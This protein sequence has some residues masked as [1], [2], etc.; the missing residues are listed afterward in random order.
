MA[1]PV[2]TQ[3]QAGALTPARATS[4]SFDITEDVLTEPLFLLHRE[5]GQMQ[6]A[7]KTNVIKLKSGS[8][9]LKPINDID[10]S[11]E[12]SDVTPYILRLSQ[13]NAASVVAEIAQ[14]RSLTELT[15]VSPSGNVATTGDYYLI[16]RTA[17]GATWNNTLTGSTTPSVLGT[18]NYPLDRLITAP[19]TPGFFETDTGFLLRLHITGAGLSNPD[20]LCGFE[21]GGSLIG[22]AT[23]PHTGFGRFWLAL[24]GDGRAQLYEYID[25]AWTQVAAWRYMSPRDV[26]GQA[27]ILRILPTAPRHLEFT[28][29]THGDFAGP[30]ERLAEVTYQFI[31]ALQKDTYLQSTYLHTISNRGELAFLPNRPRAITGAG[32][33]GFDL[34]RDLRAKFQISRL[35]YPT[36]PAVGTILERNFTLAY[37]VA[38]AHVMRPTTI[39]YDYFSGDTQKTSH[40][41]ILQ[42]ADGSSLGTASE[43]Y[44]WR[45]T[46]YSVPG[47]VPAGSLNTLRA[48]ITLT[49]LE[50]AGASFHTPV[51]VGYEVQR[52][53]HIATHAPGVKSGGNLQ[54]V[55]LSGPGYEPDQE[56]ASLVI[57]DVENELSFLRARGLASVRV[58][59]TDPADPVN[60]KVIC[61]EGYTG[62]VNAVRRGKTGAVYPSAQ[63]RRLEI[64]C[65]GKW[66]RLADRFFYQR[67]YFN[68][69]LTSPTNP[70][71]DYQPWKVTDAIRAI[72]ASQGFG[73][74]QLDIF[75]DPIRIFISP[76]GDE[77]NF[78]VPPGASIPEF[79]QMLA[80]DYLN[81]YY[82]FDYAARPSGATT[83]GMWRLRRPP[84]GTETPLWN[85]TT[86]TVSGT[87]LAYRGAAYGANTSPILGDPFEFRSYI[88]PPEGNVLTVAGAEID[89]PGGGTGTVQRQLINPTSWN[90]PTHSTASSADI[91]YIGYIKPIEYV[92]PTIGG[93]PVQAQLAIDF[94]ARRIFN[95]ACRGRKWFEFVSE[96][97]FVTDTA[98]LADGGAAYS[99]PTYARRPLLP[100]DL[101]TIDGELCVMHSVNAIW[102]KD[103][104][105]WAHYEAELFRFQ[106]T[107]S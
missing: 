20:V 31:R 27:I 13:V 11:P 42:G 105:Q 37:G 95:L 4:V 65:V 44:T 78:S 6:P 84:T 87:K 97:C 55:S 103:V 99:N 39:G 74:T 3:I 58:E 59:T 86:A 75:D 51:V 81:A 53:G 32:P 19:T 98:T 107:F 40:G 60:K 23:A 88:I 46:A 26:P 61:F 72:L 83:Q 49:N 62:R 8:F 106:N 66:N 38:A 57:Q 30:M 7:T 25:A 28:F 96:Y 85:F 77:N 21:F 10:V 14:H 9:V 1:D 12:R 79:L 50:G 41:A 33:I 64:D 17:S 73:E 76:H 24:L 34:R 102:K 47:Y 18:T 90:S 101:V 36:S 22:D 80:I 52:F 94:L 89:L 29:M 71:G 104:A 82:L 43:G 2:Y 54:S 63:W 68:R 91:D 56:T 92:D 5:A 67:T 93:D 100:G 16:R 45:G 69:D 15:G 48:V 35:A 70:T